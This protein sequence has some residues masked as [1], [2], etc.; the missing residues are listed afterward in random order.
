MGQVVP[1]QAQRTT[2]VIAT[3][4]PNSTFGAIAA[5]LGFGLLASDS[6]RRKRSRH[7]ETEHGAGRERHGT[8]LGGE[9][10]D[11]N[12]DLDDLAEMARDELDFT[13]GMMQ[14]LTEIDSEDFSAESATQQ[15]PRG[16]VEPLGSDAGGRGSAS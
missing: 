11:L 15:R 16:S 6:R 1:D 5:S 9:T 3:M 12:M 2:Q 4:A 7:L 14:D 10:S 13:H 8:S